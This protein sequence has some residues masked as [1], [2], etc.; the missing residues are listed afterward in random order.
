MKET[1]PQVK[2][3]ANF[4]FLILILFLSWWSGRYFK[5]DTEYFR[6]IFLKFPVVFSGL[7][8]VLLYVVLSFFVWFVKDILKAVGALVFGA[9]L[10]SLLVY[11]A[12]MINAVILF[13]LSHFLG[14]DFVKNQL[15]GNLAGLDE[16]VSKF[17]FWGMFTLRIVPLLPF[18]F[19]DI[20]AGL[21]RISFREYY[22]ACL[23][24]SGLRIFWLQFILSAIGLGVFKD[25]NLVTEYFL[26]NPV[27]LLFSLAYLVASII[28][29]IFLRKKLFK[30]R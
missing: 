12:E 13:N 21:T 22:L 2:N 20:A 7:A 1:S 14:R 11:T 24:G 27:I 10:S 25:V 3:L 5:I 4:L 16:R 23:L 6:G 30:P 28:L 19:L 18:R 17:G 29:G 8:F 9:I 15:K 26:S